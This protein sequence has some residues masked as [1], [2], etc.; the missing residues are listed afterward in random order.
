MDTLSKGF[1]QAF[2][3]RNLTHLSTP[4]RPHKTS[5]IGFLLLDNF[6]LPC[7]TQSL[8]VLM[9]ANLIRPGSVKVHTFSHKHAEVMSDLAIP[10]RPDTPLTDIR[11]ADL[12]LLL[13]CG[14]LRTPRTVPEW[15]VNLLKKL[16][17]WPM[18]L[19]GL[20]NG[21]WYLGRAGLLDGYRCAIHAEQRIALSERSPNANVTLERLVFDRDRIT[22]ATPAGAF[23]VMTQ[24]LG[25]A[26]DPK[27]AEAVV[28]L[29]DYDQTRFRSP[30]I[31]HRQKLSKPLR[32]LISLMESNLEEPLEPE[33]LAGYA[34][35]SKR[36]I[37]RLF[38][39]QLAT[40]PQKY[41]LQ[42][43]ITEARRLI[44]NSSLSILDVAIACGFVS[45][46][47]FSKCYSDF[48]GHPPSHEVRHEI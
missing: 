7:F 18:S 2:Q 40:T 28:E 46:S 3:P 16:A 8:D 31:T 6:S 47:H 36:Q 38:R 11:L 32:E 39:E 19:G 14:G 37:Q 42:L 48:F 15:L 24:W 13:V 35:L 29:L 20:W 45:G 5:R 21:A 23:E 1:S 43:R 22:A 26:C 30:Q 34:E 27:L 41:Y 17:D 33:R 4:P 9:T 25:K 44:Q 10:I 12:D